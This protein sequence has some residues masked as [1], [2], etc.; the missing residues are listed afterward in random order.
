MAT[1][2]YADNDDGCDDGDDDENDNDDKAGVC[3]VWCSSGVLD[4]ALKGPCA[5][6]RYA[7]FT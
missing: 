2:D 6:A 4:P 1:I 5:D 7:H 3:F